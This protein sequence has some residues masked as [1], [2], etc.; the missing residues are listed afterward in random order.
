MDYNLGLPELRSRVVPEEE[1]GGK[2]W[3][4]GSVPVKEILDPSLLVTIPGLYSRNQ[5]EHPTKIRNT[6]LYFLG[7]WS[8]P[9]QGKCALELRIGG[10]LKMVL[11]LNASRVD[12]DDERSV[13]TKKLRWAMYSI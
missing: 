2:L 10:A 13:V 1:V 3:Y 6:R 12:F 7:Y 8:L 9:L 5:G 11:L 4:D